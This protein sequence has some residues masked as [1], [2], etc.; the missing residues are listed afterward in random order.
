METILD[1][2]KSKRILSKETLLFAS[3]SKECYN[4][5]VK[6]FRRYGEI[7]NRIDT[8]LIDAGNVT[9]LWVYLR[10]EN[11]GIY[12]RMFNGEVVEL[13]ISE[14]LPTPSKE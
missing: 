13:F 11:L 14:G 7:L 12:T 1:L 8:F 4:D 3:K 2:L 6:Y 5:L 10:Q 9:K